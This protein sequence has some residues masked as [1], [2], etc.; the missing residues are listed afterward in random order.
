VA[1]TPIRDARDTLGIRFYH[2]VDHDGPASYTTGGE[3]INASVFGFKEVISVDCSGSDN[4]AHTTVPVFAT[5]GNPKSFKLMWIV[6]ATGLEVGNG[7]SLSARFVK[8]SA[9]GR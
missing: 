8:I 4:S 2:T 7:V 5:K 1:N 3:T 6:V 9:Y